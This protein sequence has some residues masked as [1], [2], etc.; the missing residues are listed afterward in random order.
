MGVKLPRLGQNW[1]SDDRM[2][3]Y[4]NYIIKAN[5]LFRKNNIYD[6]AIYSYNTDMVLKRLFPDRL[7]VLDSV[8]VVYFTLSVRYI[9]ENLGFV[10]FQESRIS[11]STK[12][13]THF[14]PSITDDS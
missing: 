7:L 10:G 13:L 1:I 5:N 14:S 2:S 3:Q 8:C 12:L 9:C 11:G 6:I 4:H